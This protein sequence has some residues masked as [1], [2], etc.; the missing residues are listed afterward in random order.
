MGVCF[1]FFLLLFICVSVEFLC[2]FIM[3]F[4]CHTHH[5]Q[6]TRAVFS[7][8]PLSLVKHKTHAQT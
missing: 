8:S 1:F 6:D 5:F 3:V 7:M 2:F 4:M